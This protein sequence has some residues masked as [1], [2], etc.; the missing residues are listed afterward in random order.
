MNKIDIENIKREL[1]KREA[2]NYEWVKGGDLT[3]D[4][5]MLR[6][7]KELNKLIDN[8][9][10]YKKNNAEAEI[11]KIVDE[12]FTEFGNEE[13]NMIILGG[14][15]YSN[16][17]RH[18]NDCTI[19]EI[20]EYINFNDEE[21]WN[22]YAHP[23][24]RRLNISYYYG[25]HWH[26]GNKEDDKKFKK[27]IKKTEKILDNLPNLP[28]K[29]IKNYWKNDNDSLNEYWYGCHAITRDYKIY[30]FVIRSDGL[31]LNAQDGFESFWNHVLYTI[32]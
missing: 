2:T 32:K 17:S 19:E 3:K 14:G 23:V 10:N 18:F 25:Y 8:F 16:D 1:A 12:I 21:R 4:D 11:K 7:T 13:D 5:I 9:N 6:T 24:G 20:F 26:E 29:S 15:N 22:P 28:I 27:L 31:F 30:A